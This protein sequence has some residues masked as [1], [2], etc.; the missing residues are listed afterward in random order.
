MKFAAALLSVAIVA[1]PLAARAAAPTPAKPAA[2]TAQPT[3]AKRCSP[4]N[5]KQYCE[6]YQQLVVHQKGQV[7]PVRVIEAAV[8]YPVKGGQAKG[9]L[10]MPLGVAVDTPSRVQ[11][12][13]SATTGFP[14]HI[15][16][17]R[18]DGCYAAFDLTPAIVDEMRAAKKMTVI[19]PAAD[20]KN[21][22][23]VMSMNGF[24]A[25]LDSVK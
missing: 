13:D 17:C 8:G 12:G 25:I 9:A 3:W 14:V 23:I 18:A 19:L 20:G 5:G 2:A 7:R 24:A 11:I 6:A 15:H 21:V 4:V 1:A 22:A 16:V 10:I